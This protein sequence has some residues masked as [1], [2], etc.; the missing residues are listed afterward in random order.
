MEPASIPQAEIEAMVRR[1]LAKVGRRYMPLAIGLVILI[2]IVTL[3]PTVSPK[4]SRNAQAGFGSGDGAAGPAGGDTGSTTAAGAGAGA[5]TQT[6][7]GLPSAGGGAIQNSTLTAAAGITPPAA[8]GT[9]GV[10]RSGIECGPGVLQVPW[11]V[12]APPCIPAYAG[13]NGASTSFGITK[14]AI[15]LSFRRT[16]SVEEKAAF[17]AVGKAAPGTDDQYLADLRTYLRLFNKTYELYGRQVVVKDFTGQGDNLQE[18]QGQNL[19]GA[20]ADAAHAKDLGA[21]MDITQSPSLAGTQ[22]YL[23]DLAQQRVIGIGGIGLP[24]S[25]FQRNAP[26]EFATIFPDGTKAARGAA[27]ALCARLAGLPAAFAG[28]PVYQHRTRVFGLVTPENDVYVELGNQLQT[29]ANQQ[30]GAN[31]GTPIRYSINVATEAQQ[32]V[33]IIAKLHSAGV[34]TVACVCDP[35]AEITLSDAAD[36]QQYKPEWF[37]SPWLDPQGREVSQSQWAHAISGE[38]TYPLKLQS[39]AY[40]VYKIANPTGEPQEQYYFFAYY[41]LQYVLTS[42]QR[43]GPSLNPATFQQAVL[44]MPRTANGDLGTWAGGPT[45]YTPFLTGQMGYWDPNA[46]SNFDNTKGAWVSCE[47]GKWFAFN[48]PSSFGPH[49]QPHCFGK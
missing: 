18:D 40:R 17:A 45:Q 1:Y 15:T 43:A 46:I 25:W 39:E 28:D 34:T 38:G 44:S 2:L 27:N 26:Y 30:C 49:Q 5:G 42:L 37:P 4:Q 47:G 21:F 24:L 14:D 6:A 22:P 3:V 10:T 8:P 33:S 48:D 32:S 12:Y 19:Q 13:N 36:S 11:S 16:S 9:R 41:M 29:F 31:F 20:Q 23:E 35:I 7:A